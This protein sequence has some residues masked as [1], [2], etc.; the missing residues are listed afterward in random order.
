MPVVQNNWKGESSMHAKKRLAHIVLQTNQLAAVKDWYIKVLDAH[1]V[2]EN[3][4][5]SFLAFDEEHHRLAIAQIPGLVERTPLTVGLFHSAF[6]FD[7]LGELLAK[8]EELKEYG[9]EPRMPVQHG[10]TTSIYYRD[11]DGNFVELQIDNFATADEATEY[12]RSPEYTTEPIGPSFDPA[13]MLEAFRAGT[14]ESELLTRAWAS[15]NP[16]RDFVEQMMS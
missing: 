16:Q 13:I 5:I 9:I 6:T 12:M 2:Y 8:Y 15:T 10:V 11:P 3:P 7:S 1:V 4:M 14:P